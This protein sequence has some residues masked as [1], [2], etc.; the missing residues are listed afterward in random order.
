MITTHKR[1]LISAYWSEWITAAT[2]QQA[3]NIVED[4]LLGSDIKVR[5]FEIIC[6]EED[7]QP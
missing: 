6:Q 2:R 1:Y 4:M 3:L 7:V 5:D